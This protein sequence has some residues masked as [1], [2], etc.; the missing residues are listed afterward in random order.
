MARSKQWDASQYK[1]RIYREKTTSDDLTF[2]HVAVNETDL[3]VSADRPLE[4]QTRDL[5]LA[6]RHQIETYIQHHPTF[7]RSLVPFPADPF[8][9]PIVKEMIQAAA[10][11]QVGP[12]SSVAGIIAAHVA[13]GLLEI[14]DQV[15]V[16]NGGD[17]FLKT[18][19]AVTISIFAGPSPL[20]DKLGLN[21]KPAQMPLGVCSS[22]KTVGHSLSL[23]GTDVCCVL[24]PSA[25]LA[26]AAA[27]ALGNRVKDKR[28]LNK[29]SDWA[30]QI[31]GILGGVV[32]VDDHMTA[33]GDIELVDL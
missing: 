27:T 11:V 7:V 19:R 10:M 12:M 23:G 24:S 1:N 22:S 30:G 15:I 20:S 26:D 18:D 32:I 14:T 16:E 9:P 6:C 17:I 8:A 2:F 4:A 33:W 25:A 31:D 21:V 5:V 28:D 3:W 29:V 13:E